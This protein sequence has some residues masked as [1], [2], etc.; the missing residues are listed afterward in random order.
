MSAVMSNVTDSATKLSIVMPVRNDGI[1]LLTIVK[2]IEAIV[3]TPHEIIVV[4]DSPDDDC[5]AAVAVLQKQ[6]ANVFRVHN[7]SGRGV[8][9]ALTAGIETAR[10]DYIVTY[11]ADD[12]GPALILDKMVGLMESGCDYL[13][14]TRYAHGGRCFGGSPAEKVLSRLANKTF[15]YLSASALTDCTMGFKM[16]RRSIFADFQLSTEHAGWSFAFEMAIKAQL[17]GLRIGEV[18]IV[19]INRPYEG[20]STL[21]LYEWIRVYLRWYFYGV[22]RLHLLRRKSK[23]V[24]FSAVAQ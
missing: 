1:N 14:M 15:R 17:M 20:K 5:V 13:N 22:R 21:K 4:H 7:T 8:V 3:T 12:I 9:R 6:F 10:G 19:S 24:V 11:A 16:F 2:I 23:P 18:P